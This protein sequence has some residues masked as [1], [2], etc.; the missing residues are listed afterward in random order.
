MRGPFALA[1]IVLV[2]ACASTHTVQPILAS[3]SVDFSHAEAVE[4]A[5]SSFKFTPEELQLTAGKPY[6]LKFEDTAAGEHDFTAPEFFAAAQVHPDDSSRIADGQVELE[7]GES[8]SIRLVPGKGE[9]KIVCT[10]FGHSALGMT[11]KI[12]VR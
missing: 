9:Y 2:G 11:G 1:A 7:G 10:H 6:L 12:V 8:A 5:L 4:V 3:P